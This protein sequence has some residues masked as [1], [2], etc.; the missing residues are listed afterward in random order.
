MTNLPITSNNTS[1]PAKTEPGATLQA[2]SVMN[3]QT[4][5][6]FS[7][8]LKRQIIEA[9]DTDTATKDT[10]DPAAIAANTSTLAAMLMHSPFQHTDARTRK[11]STVDDLRSREDAPANGGL[12]NSP[13]GRIKPKIENGL[14]RATGRSI[15]KDTA[16]NLADP[17][18]LPDS[19]SLIAL[20]SGYLK[21]AELAFNSAGQPQTGQNIPNAANAMSTF[22][23]MTPILTRSISADNSQTVTTPLGNNGWADEFS[24]KIIWISTQQNQIAELHLNPPGLGPLNIVL[25]VSDNQLTA[26]FT[27]PHSAVREAVENAL[28]K[29]RELLADNSIMLGNA[30][31]SDQPP[32]DRGTEG[33]MK[34]GSRM[35]EQPESSY[36]VAAA[37]DLSPATA[38]GMPVRRHNG[39]LDTFA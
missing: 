29:L 13:L 2:N 5:E 19:S 9:G 20:T 22:T 18:Q 31:V 12:S 27:S 11:A 39:M 25:T 35:A 28:P 10:Q 6:P 30:T 16:L 32:R 8:L 4:A 3:N 37:N 23:G 33:F 38:Q 17:Q 7:A 36:N 24:Q 14:L 26:Q 34:Q 1:S 15:E 21:H